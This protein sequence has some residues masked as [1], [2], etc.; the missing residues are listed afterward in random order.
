MNERQ[1]GARLTS[2]GASFRLAAPAAEHVDLLPERPH[3]EQRGADR[4]FSAEIPG[5]PWSVFWPME[6]R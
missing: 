2:E 6:S 1:F 3:P 5:A 4:C